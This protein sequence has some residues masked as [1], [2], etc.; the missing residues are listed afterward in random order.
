MIYTYIYLYIY[1]HPIFTNIYW[2]HVL[3]PLRPW[4]KTKCKFKV[5]CLFRRN[6]LRS[7]KN[8]FSQPPND[9]D[10]SLSKV[11]SF[12]IAPG[13]YQHLLKFFNCDMGT[14]WKVQQ[15]WRKQNS[16]QH[17]SEQPSCFR[18]QETWLQQRL[19]RQTSRR[20]GCLRPKARWKPKSNNTPCASSLGSQRSQ[21]YSKWAKKNCQQCAELVWGGQRV[22]LWAPKTGLAYSVGH[23][24]YLWKLC[25]HFARDLAD[26]ENSLQLCATIF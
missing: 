8:T 6:L 21:C 17:T 18:G 9:G 22:C 13:I 25:C 26:T 1:E 11:K 20:K 23:Y 7:K 2:Y 12:G 5:F 10:Q 19:G 3:R 16:N 24:W 15:N 14:W 4:S